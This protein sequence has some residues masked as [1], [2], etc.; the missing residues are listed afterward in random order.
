MNQPLATIVL[1]DGTEYEMVPTGFKWA[2]PPLNPIGIFDK[3]SRDRV[4]DVLRQV[5]EIASRA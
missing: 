5:A 3:H 1:L 4:V 2:E